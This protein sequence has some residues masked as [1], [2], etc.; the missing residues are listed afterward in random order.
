MLFREDLETRSFN[1][2]FVDLGI[3]SGFPSFSLQYSSFSS[4]EHDAKS[5][6]SNFHF[7]K[8]FN[9][10]LIII[11]WFFVFQIVRVAEAKLRCKKRRL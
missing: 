11:Y 8:D 10:K 3:I 4:T 9:D 5:A 6:F 1:A 2:Y 7:Q